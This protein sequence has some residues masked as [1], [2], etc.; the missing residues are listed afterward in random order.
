MTPSGRRAHAISTIIPF[1]ERAR[2]FSGWNFDD[3]RVTP[4]DPLFANG[5][6]TPWDYVA[7]AREYAAR[8]DRVVD[9][10]SGGGEVFSRVV[11][12]LKGP[13]FYAGEEWH[14]NAPVAR[15]RLVP[16]GVEVLHASSE[17]T[18]YR[19]ES[20]DVVLSRHEAIEPP[21]IAWILQPGGVFLTQQVAKE[22]WRE[23]TPL[24]PNRTVFPD[25]FV[26]YARAFE[27]AGL[28]VTTQHH[29]WRAAYA[30]IGE[31]AFMLMISPWEFP[32]FDAMREIDSLLALEDAYGTED[33]IVLTL[34]RYLLIAR[35]PAG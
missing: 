32:E 13:R 6:E 33:G 29:T 28:T 26:D 31:V 30:S 24:F 20:F 17:R 21:D 9:L 23:L 16:L 22:Q 10:G 25:H 35:K 5:R 15:E 34:A 19:N 1:M 18:P 12:G 7:L 3:L 4:L 27:E 14:V 11:D 8:A 2:T